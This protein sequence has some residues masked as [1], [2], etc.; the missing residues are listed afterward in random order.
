[1][2]NRITSK[3][4]RKLFTATATIALMGLSAT[5][6][7]ANSLIA[8]QYDGGKSRVNR[9]FALRG[10]T[11]AFA[12]AACRYDGN[13]DIE[14]ARY[15]LQHVH[16]NFEAVLHGLEH[17][18]RA[19]GM[20][21]EE[22]SPRILQAIAKTHE[23]WDPMEE[24]SR[25]MLEGTSTPK[26]VAIITE[27]YHDLFEQT[28]IM[29]ADV[30]GE[31]TNPQELL[32]S[33]ATILNFAGRQRMLAQRM[34][35]AVCELA[36]DVHV[37]VAISELTATVDMFDLSLVALRD[38]YPAAGVNPPPNETVK[39][40]LEDAYAL[41]QANR[42]IYDTI[43]S[44]THA[45]ADDVA[46]SNAM[47]RELMVS[48]N[49][50]ITLYLLATP[51]KDGVYR[52]PLEAYAETEL[53]TWINDPRVIEAVK[54]QNILHADLSQADIDALDQQ[55]RAEAG[56]DGGPMMTAAL[57]SPVSEWLL[58]HQDTTA[59]FITEAFV[60]DMH[61]LNVA[62]SVAT[63]DYWQGDEAKYQETYLIGPDALHI[64]D[65]ELDESTGFY[66]A[67]ASL[68]VVDPATGEVIGA[69]TFGV[70]VQSLM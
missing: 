66:Q 61:G 36:S 13:Y 5:P 4:H 20:P 27:G 32:Q 40:S 67:Q 63:S 68:P 57:S 51:G 24:A 38:G 18:D 19:L 44:G 11:E 46:A 3:T 42:G 69:M 9:A 58:E 48:M 22:T 45:T 10:V 47:T 65:V 28:D 50:V 25:H 52:V 33:D 41:W 12:S 64:S 8:E 56:A 54:A 37:D 60:M 43:L 15:D 26:E 31:Y 35:R 34:T 59:G 23:L 39:K 49:N 6:V 16:D 62:Q 7:A 1:M 30:S 55:W 21:G 53:S 29:A 17:G 2:Q 70:N 14:T